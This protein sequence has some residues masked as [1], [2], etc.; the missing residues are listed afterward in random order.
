MKQI[1]KVILNKIL[2]LYIKEYFCQ[3]ICKWIEHLP[4]SD[5]SKENKL[6]CW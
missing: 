4:Y 6:K 1:I 2:N 3:K 5:R